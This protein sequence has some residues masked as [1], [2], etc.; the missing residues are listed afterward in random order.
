MHEG[1]SWTLVGQTTSRS[2]AS[3]TCAEG[4]RGDPLS[5]SSIILRL[6]QNRTSMEKGFLPPPESQ[7]TSRLKSV[8]N[9]SEK[10][11]CE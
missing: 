9:G 6:H 10:G 11:S 5:S 3:S 4:K 1:P 8:Q 2:N 7:G